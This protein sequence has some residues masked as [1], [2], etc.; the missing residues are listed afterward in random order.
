MSACFS[1]L[2]SCLPTVVWQAPRTAAFVAYRLNATTFLINEPDDIY[3]ESP[4]I[5]A[6]MNYATNTIVLIDTGCGGHTRRP[7]ISVKSLREFIETIPVDV[8]GKKPINEGGKMKYVIVIT[9]CHYDHICQSSIS[10]VIPILT[11]RLFC[12]A[13]PCTVGTEP[14]AADTPILSSG[15]DPSFLTPDQ[16]QYSS[17]C[18]Y[19]GIKLP[20]YTPTLVPHNYSIPQSPHVHVLHTPGHTPDEVAIWDES[21]GMLYVGDTLYDGMPV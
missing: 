1:A 18:A 14:F 16:L 4:Y 9:H 15:N 5:Y 11:Q 12:L 3:G 19:L 8:N 21:E 2:T 20:K 13:W 10:R 17:L 7:G 6:L